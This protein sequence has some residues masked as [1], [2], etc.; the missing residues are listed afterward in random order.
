[1]VL[2]CGSSAQPEC[3]ASRKDQAATYNAGNGASLRAPERTFDS[4]TRRAWRW[5]PRRGLLVLWR[6]AAGGGQPDGVRPLHVAA[7]RARSP[8]R[9][10]WSGV[11]GFRIGALPA[12]P[13]LRSICILSEAAILTG[14]TAAGRQKVGQVLGGAIPDDRI[15]GTAGRGQAVAR[16]GVAHAVA[17]PWSVVRRRGAILWGQSADC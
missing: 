3:A 5:R 17:G 1:M 9:D 8:G 12:I 15:I 10:R 16:C 11:G 4:G 6:A 2:C 7:W 14:E 13:S